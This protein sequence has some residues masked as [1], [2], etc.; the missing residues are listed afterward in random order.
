MKRVNVYAVIREMREQIVKTMQER[1]ITELAMFKSYQEWGK[2][3]NYSPDDYEEDENHD[4]DYTDYKDCEAPYAIFFD[5]HGMGYDYRVDKVRLKTYKDSDPV[6]LFDCHESE[7]GDD[8]FGEDDM[9][10]LTLYNVYD[11]ML[12]LLEIED[13]P[14]PIWVLFAESLYDYELVRRVINV[15]EN[16]GDARKAFAEEVKEARK[17]ATTNE[18]VIGNDNENFFEAYPDGSWGTSHETV[19]L[20]KTVMNE[21]ITFRN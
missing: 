11:T 17:C 5:K 18:W 2:E 16:E 15:F 14:S 3:R 13:E 10:F 9:V 7:L 12:D 19:E 20:N 8:T 6:L 4:Y 1:G 21:K